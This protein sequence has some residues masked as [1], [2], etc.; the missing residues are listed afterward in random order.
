M[1]GYLGL[2]DA[3]VKRRPITQSPGE[4]NGAIIRDI[5]GVD[6]FVTVSQKMWDRLKVIL[7]SIT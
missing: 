4:W 6:F 7:E 1:M 3:T 2:K 5:E